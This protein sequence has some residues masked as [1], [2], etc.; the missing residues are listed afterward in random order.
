[1]TWTATVTSGA[2]GRAR[3][4]ALLATIPLV[5]LVLYALVVADVIPAASVA[6]W[7]WVVLVLL[8]VALT[9]LAMRRGLI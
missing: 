4:R 9:A 3:R 1:M 7:I 6:G 8:F 5:T 2:T